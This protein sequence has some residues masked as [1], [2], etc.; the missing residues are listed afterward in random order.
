MKLRLVKNLN[1]SF[2]LPVEVLP[3]AWKQVKEVISEMNGSSKLRMAKEKAGPVV[4]DQGNLILDVLF[5]DG[6]KNPKDMK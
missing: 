4:T 2:P 1:K 5:I 3:N 6:I